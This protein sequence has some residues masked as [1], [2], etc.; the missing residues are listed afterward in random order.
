MKVTFTAKRGI[1]AEQFVDILKRSTLA[2]RRPVEDAACI[3]GMIRHAN[4]TVTAWE[5]EML[6][7]IARSVTDFHFA[8]Y[9]S[10]LAVDAAYQHAGIGRELIRRTQGELGPRCKIRLISAPAAMGY[11][12]KLGFTQNMQCWELSPPRPR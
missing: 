3:E 9:L 6:I 5:G 8:C 2:E 7:G 4:L 11:Y 12:P 10:D 1:T